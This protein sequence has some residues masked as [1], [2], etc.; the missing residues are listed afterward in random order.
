MSLLRW[1]TSESSAAENY[2]E[3]RASEVMYQQVCSSKT[4]PILILTYFRTPCS[5]LEMC[6]V[7]KWDMCEG[8]IEPCKA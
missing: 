5:V 7:I 3:I 8:E 6:S 4:S 2:D 1:S